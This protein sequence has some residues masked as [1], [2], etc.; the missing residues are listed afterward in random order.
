LVAGLRIGIVVFLAAQKIFRSNRRSGLLKWERDFDLEHW[1][2]TVFGLQIAVESLFALSLSWTKMERL[3]QRFLCGRLKL[4]Q[5]WGGISP[6]FAHFLWLYLQFAHFCIDL[7][8]MGSCLHGWM[9]LIAYS[10]IWFISL[11]ILST[12]LDSECNVQIMK[13][14]TCL[15]FKAYISYSNTLFQSYCVSCPR[16][17]CTSVLLDCT[18]SFAPSIR[19][20]RGGFGNDLIVLA[21][22]WQANLDVIVAC[23]WNRRTLYFSSAT[24]SMAWIDL[25]LISSVSNLS[26]ICK[27]LVSEAGRLLLHAYADCRSQY[28]LRS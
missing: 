1:N 6:L 10:K 23:G 28:R 18:F 7:R 11:K 8:E 16:N 5:E 21:I 17:W 25:G 24:C 19:G 27:N 2:S 13:R 3:L 20:S 26:T 12:E 15:L 4:A 9:S 22:I 14:K